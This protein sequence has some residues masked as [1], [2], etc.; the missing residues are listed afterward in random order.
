MYTTLEE[1]QMKLNTTSTNLS[2]LIPVQEKQQQI[3][4]QHMQLLYRKP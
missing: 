3:T 2:G 1:R 4:S